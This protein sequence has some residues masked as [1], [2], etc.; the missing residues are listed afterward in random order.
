MFCLLH[1]SEILFWKNQY[2]IFNWNM[3]NKNTDMMQEE[4]F[5]PKN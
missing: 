2:K 5:N 1:E 4:I 3:E